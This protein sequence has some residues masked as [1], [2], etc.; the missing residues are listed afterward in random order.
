MLDFALD[1]RATTPL[2]CPRRH[3]FQKGGE[4]MAKKKAAKKKKK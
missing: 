2:A 3:P 4:L 1:R